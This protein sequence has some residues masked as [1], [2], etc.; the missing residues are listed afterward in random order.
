MGLKTCKF[1][2]TSVADAGKLRQVKAIIEADP[3]RRY[4][5]PSAP[6]KRSSDDVKVT[7]MLYAC[8][9]RGV[10]GEPAEAVFEPIRER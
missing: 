10:A 4:V 5:V 6:G 7:D 1:G 8:H 9:E 2:G 3:E